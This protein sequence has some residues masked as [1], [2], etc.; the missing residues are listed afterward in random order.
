MRHF[1]QLLQLLT[2]TIAVMAGSSVQAGV[3]KNVILLIGD[4]LGFEHVNA[5]AAYAGERMFFESF[6]Y[7]GEVTTHSADDAITDSAAGGT[8]IATGHKVNNGVVSMA[9]PGDGSDLPT[10]LEVAKSEGKQVG[11]VTTSNLLDATPAAFAA[12]TSFRDNFAEILFDMF[13]ESQPH[14]LMGGGSSIFGNPA[15]APL[16]GVGGYTLVADR[17]EMYA[18]DTDAETMV[19]G[20]FAPDHLPYEY[21]GMG[22]APHL[23]EMTEVALD[24]LDNNPNGFFVMIEGAKIDKASHDN[25]LE[26]TIFEVLEFDNAVRKAFEWADGRD[27]TLIIVTADHE[28]GGLLML[29]DNG[30]G[31]MPTVYWGTE[32]HSAANVPVYAWGVNAHLIPPVMDNTGFF[33]LIH[34][35]QAPAP[36]VPE[37]T[38]LAVFALGLGLLAAGRHVR[39]K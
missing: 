17:D 39:R 36:V 15:L 14:V 29:A 30:P 7:Q 12:H 22:N 28:T 38:S 1:I 23:S 34:L 2:I 25:D 33:N 16:L 8:A 21:D 26:R 24:L 10:L 32:D 20:H 31:N 27:D 3:L 4:G 13:L 37:P 5:A 11:M 6:P 9:L 19:L 18:L 35:G